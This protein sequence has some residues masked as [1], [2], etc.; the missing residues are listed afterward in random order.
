M[1]AKASG[2]E[3]KKVKASENFEIYEKG[4]NGRLREEMN[5]NSLSNTLSWPIEFKKIK[6][7][8]LPILKIISSETHYI[9]LNGSLHD[10]GGCYL[11]S[12]IC[13]LSNAI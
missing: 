8:V 11:N 5:A 13:L 12:K 4:R 9:A 7:G 10:I 2:Q 3:C 1:Q 6:I